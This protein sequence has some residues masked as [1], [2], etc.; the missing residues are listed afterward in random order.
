MEMFWSELSR[1]CVGAVFNYCDSNISKIV[2][3]IL[4]RTK[5][6]TDSHIGSNAFTRKE[7]IDNTLQTL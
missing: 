3:T 4:T 1:S 7:I 2:E 6:W 5:S